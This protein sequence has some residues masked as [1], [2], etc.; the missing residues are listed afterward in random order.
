MIAVDSLTRGEI[1]EEWITLT[2]G[3]ILI[4]SASSAPASSHP[5]IPS[6]ASPL[7][8]APCFILLQRSSEMP[9]LVV[10]LRPDEP[11]RAL[12][13]R[14]LPDDADVTYLVDLP[15]DQRLDA[16]TDADAVLAWNPFRELDGRELDALQ[17]VEFLQLLSAGADHLD[18]SRLPA[19]LQVASNAGAYA[20][21]VAEGVVALTLALARRL[22]EEHDNLSA[23][24][25]N[26]RLEV[27]TLMGASVAILGF[28]GIGRQVARFLEPWNVDLYVF[29]TSGTTDREVAW[30]GTLDELDAILPCVD[31][32]VL[33]LPLTPRTR[34]LFDAERLARMKDTAMLVN[35]ARGEIIDQQALYDH[36]VAHPHFK[37][38][39]EAWWVEPFRHG[40]FR[41]EAPL[42]DLPNVIGCPHNSAVIPGA[43]E[44][45]VERAAANLARH[46]AGDDPEGLLDRAAYLSN[47]G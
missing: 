5:A 19:H 38:G 21:P 26:Q 14:Q 20:E 44:T 47:S 29:N 18:F 36:L 6:P 8:S 39:L 1:W 41:L 15:D 23:G 16:L 33:C 10:T 40:E 22:R 12:I 28:G 42:L 32:A 2:L 7:S 17:H 45:G 13:A 4:G 43:L 31:V 27:Q 34:Q 11:W 46:L 25:F 37:A 9:E 3:G 35:V 30:C 24:R